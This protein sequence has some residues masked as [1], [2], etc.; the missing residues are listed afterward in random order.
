MDSGRAQCRCVGRRTAYNEDAGR[1]CASDTMVESRS[2]LF[3]GRSLPVYHSDAA[4]ILSRTTGFIARAGFTHS[5][6]PARNCVYGCSYCYVPTLGIYGGLKPLDWQRWGRHTT[7]KSNAAEL[8][9]RQLRPTQVVYCSPLVDPY[10]PAEEAE[11]LMPRILEGLTERPPAVFVLQTRGTLAVRD[12]PLLRE[13]AKR[14]R[15]RVSFSLTTN[16]EDVREWYEPHCEPVAARVHAM[17]SLV[18]AGIPV[19]CTLAP[20]LPC[21]P[22]RLA[23]LAL[24][25]TSRGVIADPLHNRDGKPRGATTRT[26]ALQISRVRGFEQWHRSRFQSE[27]LGEIRSRV[28]ASGRAFGVGE[29]GFRMLTE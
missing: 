8:L 9:R 12:I 18:G 22:S 7:Y 13:L 26:E 28:E 4:S 29:K 10:Q 24:G 11:R 21:D 6:T 27:V 20:I 25:A 16:R 14:T 19:H 2:V 1:A 15:L 23:D 5:L 3:R 17:E